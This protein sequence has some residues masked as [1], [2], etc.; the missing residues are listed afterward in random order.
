M[1]FF[2]NI[3]IWNFNF[4]F[5]NG[6][7]IKYLMKFSKGLFDE[8]VQNDFNFLLYN[9]REIIYLITDFGG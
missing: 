2:F 1:S 8:I 3:L 9:Y 4:D 6:L 5:H 7:I